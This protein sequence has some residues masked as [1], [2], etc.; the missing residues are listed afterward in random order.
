MKKNDIQEFSIFGMDSMPIQNNSYMT[1]M[2]HRICDNCGY[3]KDTSRSKSCSN[4]HFICHSGMSIVHSVG[5]LWD[6]YNPCIYAKFNF[7]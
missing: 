1:E 3:Y 2:D 4:G 5:I 6:S 7:S